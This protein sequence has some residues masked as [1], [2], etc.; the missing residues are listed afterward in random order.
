MLPSRS[1]A[2][3]SER[4]MLI[5]RKPFDVIQA[6]LNAYNTRNIAAFLSVFHEDAEVS[7]LGSNMPSMKGKSEIA[8]RYAELFAKSPNLYSHIVN[9]TVF[10]RVV[11]DLED[12]VG[13]NGT[14]S[15]ARHL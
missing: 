5:Q 6:Q 15:R 10:G 3:L 8:A 2:P 1:S 13:R 7:E 4:I 9:R 12:I 14:L 11:I